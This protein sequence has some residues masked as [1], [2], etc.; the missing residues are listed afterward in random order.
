MFLW[1]QADVTSV[2]TLH[3]FTSS[4]MV[5]PGK[6]LRLSSPQAR[7]GLLMLSER[8]NSAA[9]VVIRA[10]ITGSSDVFSVASVVLP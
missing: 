6:S 3:C 2:C 8:Y 7:P 9:V 4:F 10:P 5:Y 1:G